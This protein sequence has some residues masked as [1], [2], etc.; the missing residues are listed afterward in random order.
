MTL[1]AGF[2]TAATAAF[3]AGGNIFQL[4]MIPAIGFSVATST[5]VGQNIGAKNIVR[6][7]QIV[8]IASLIS[9]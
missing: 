2:G 8:K 3:G 1:I 7:E 9:F 5:M 4:V 6:A